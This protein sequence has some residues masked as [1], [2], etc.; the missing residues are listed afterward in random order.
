MFV[1]GIDPFAVG[2]EVG[3]PALISETGTNFRAPLGP[4]AQPS[5]HP[6]GPP[7]A[8]QNPQAELKSF[9]VGQSKFKPKI[10]K[11]TLFQNR[12]YL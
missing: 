8:P 11:A 6:T 5:P 9:L 2:R 4:R 1:F 10:A 7:L 12:K 3:G